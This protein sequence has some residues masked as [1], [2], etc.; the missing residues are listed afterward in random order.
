M[1]LKH[2]LSMYIS[3]NDLAPNTVRKLR[4]RLN[5]WLRHSAARAVSDVTS[6]ACDAFRQ[7]ARS[8]GLA[9]RTIEETVRDVGRIAGTREIGKSLKGW[10]VVT[11]R[12]VP[13]LELFETAYRNADSAEWPV[14]PGLR[15]P[16]LATVDNGTFLRA[17]LVTI[18]LTALRES[19]MR[20]LRWDQINERR[21]VFR[22]SKTSREH[23]FPVDRVVQRHLAPL[24]DAS[25]SD[26]VFPVSDGQARYLRRT[27]KEIS[28]CDWFTAQPARR[29]SVTDWIAADRTAGE[30]IHGCGLGV[31]KHYVD[32]EHVLRQALLQRSWPA[33]FL[34]ADERELQ[35]LQID[36]LLAVARRM[37]DEKLGDFIRIGG[38]LS[39]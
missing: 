5:C 37:T 20:R 23:V 16:E 29:R 2:A 8:A 32:G 4:H 19:D 15:T 24:R 21:I 18:Y 22:A 6:A 26:R 34:T 17:Y 14:W 9:L 31:L 1:T 10:K 11:C 7:A 13:E 25:K 3:D 27:L 12:P 30:I 33:A 39:A 38:A 36:A 28:G 35:T